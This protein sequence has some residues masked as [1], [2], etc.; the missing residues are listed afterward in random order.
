[1]H[2]VVVDSGIRYKYRI[3]ER[4]LEEG[5]FVTEVFADIGLVEDDDGGW[6][7]FARVDSAACGDAESEWVVGHAENDDACMFRCVVGD[8]AKMGFDNVVAVQER[9]LAIGLDP[10]LV[11]RILRQVVKRS[12]M[13]TKLARLAKLAKTGAQG[14]EIGPTD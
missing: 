6:I 4:G 1:M 2:G 5:V 3:E 7:D 11:F 12:D 13:Q 10:H 9:Q 8:T 14:H